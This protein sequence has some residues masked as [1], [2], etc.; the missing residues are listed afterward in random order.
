MRFLGIFLAICTLDLY[1]SGEIMRPYLS[2][3]RIKK[4]GKGNNNLLKHHKTQEIINKTHII[5]ESA[6]KKPFLK[7]PVKMSGLVHLYPYGSPKY[8]AW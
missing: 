6:S 1:M 5:S 7:T 2:H 3:F 4:V 8:Q